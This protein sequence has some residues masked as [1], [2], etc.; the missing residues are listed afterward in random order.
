MP[1]SAFLPCISLKGLS[2]PVLG[3]EEEQFIGL[4]FM[5]A[6]F[7]SI[8]IW[9]IHVFVY[10]TFN[11]RQRIRSSYICY[12]RQNDAGVF[13]T[14]SSCVEINIIAKTLILKLNFV[15]NYELSGNLLKSYHDFN[16]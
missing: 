3:N 12:C 7:N 10:F 11:W 2:F 1:K 14:G 13:F 8:I 9:H 6:S 16:K 5:H 4:D 15:P